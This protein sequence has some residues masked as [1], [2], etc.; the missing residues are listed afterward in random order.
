LISR[1]SF[2]QTADLPLELAPVNG[3]VPPPAPVRAIPARA[4]NEGEA[5]V[6]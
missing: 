2:A 1:A 4:A 3:N 5:S 6:A